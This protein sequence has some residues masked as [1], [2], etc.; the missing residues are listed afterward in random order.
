MRYSFFGHES[1][2]CKSLW[3]K[4]GYDFINE[5]HKFS[6]PNSVVL[7]GVGKNMVSSIRYWMRAF[8]LIEDDQLTDY[9][10]FIFDEH[11]GK[12]PFAEDIN[13]LWILHF[14]LVT[15]SVASIYRLVFLDLQREK[16]DFDKEQILLFIKRKCS[17]PEQKNVF[18]ENTVKKDIRVFLQNYLSPVNP[19]SLEEYTG[20][21]IS[22]GLLREND[23]VYSFSETSRE[24]I[25]PLIIYF[26]LIASS[27]ED[28]TISFDKLQELSLLF[29]I[30]I[31]VFLQMVRDLSNEFPKEI[32]YTDNSG[33]RNVQFL[34]KLNAFDILN[35]YYDSHE[36]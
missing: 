25:N 21:L 9:A 14:L 26:A 29:C 36:L 33:I 23:G 34:K 13:T 18:N 17:V 27:Q 10:K 19:K 22:L 6:D 2:L 20:L 30:P 8:N 11:Q 7:L 12:D 15:T 5:H 28:L 24:S 16:R 3:L 35:K 1:F 4:K 31:T 32:V